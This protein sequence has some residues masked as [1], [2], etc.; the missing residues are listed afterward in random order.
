M[1]SPNSSEFGYDGGSVSCGQVDGVDGAGALFG[2]DRKL[3]FFPCLGAVG[4]FVAGGQAAQR[5]MAGADRHR[6]IDADACGVGH[7]V[8]ADTTADFAGAGVHPDQ[9]V[10]DDAPVAVEDLAMDETVGGD[11]DVE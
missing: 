4:E 7:F 1:P 2:L 10:A 11:F 5:G 9:L 8:A 3:A 6:G